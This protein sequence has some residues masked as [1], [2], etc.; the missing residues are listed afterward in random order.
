MN[1]IPDNWV[2]VKVDED[3][4]KVLAGWSGGYLDGDSWRLN[5]GISKVKDD[6]DYWLFIGASGS[7]YQCH[8]KGYGIRMNIVTQVKQ[9]KELGCEVMPEETDWMKLV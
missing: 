9:L 4:Y 8:K 2:V 1:N 5:S 3:F 6:G 7:V